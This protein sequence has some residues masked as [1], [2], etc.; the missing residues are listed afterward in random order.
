MGGFAAECPP[1]LR[2]YCH[3]EDGVDWFTHSVHTCCCAYRGLTWLARMAAR[4]ARRNGDMRGR[5]WLPVPT[6]IQF[7]TCSMSGLDPM[8]CEKWEKLCTSKEFWSE[9]KKKE[10]SLRLWHY[11]MSLVDAAVLFITKHW[12]LKNAAY[13]T[14]EHSA[15]GHC[16]K[17]CTGCHINKSE[18]RQFLNTQVNKLYT[19]REK[20][21]VKQSNEVLRSMKGQ[22][23]AVMLQ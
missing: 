14:N 9:T 6:Y 12:K 19:V 8:R 18:Q 23:A 20:L 4:L 17:W 22:W 7:F 13:N 15:S 16:S 10:N 3:C 1:W 21:S 2:A 5:A 11:N